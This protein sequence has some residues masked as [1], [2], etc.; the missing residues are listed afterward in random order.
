MRAL[1]FIFF[2]SSISFFTRYST[3]TELRQFK[4]AVKIVLRKAAIIME[5][6]RV[7][8]AMRKWGLAVY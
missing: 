8:R 1:P 4:T 5:K 6:Y 2:Y 3:G 7:Y